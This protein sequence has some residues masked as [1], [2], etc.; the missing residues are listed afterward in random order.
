[1]FSVLYSALA[2]VRM[3]IVFTVFS[4]GVPAVAVRRSRSKD[5]AFPGVGLGISCPN[6]LTN[7][8]S[9]F[10]FSGSGRSCTRYTAVR[11]GT[12]FSG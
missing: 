11:V 9:C 8:R 4:S 5:S 1:M 3:D 2:M 10:S 7:T 6:R 12:C